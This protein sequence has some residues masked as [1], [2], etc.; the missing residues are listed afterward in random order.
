MWFD[1]VQRY[2]RAI[3]VKGRGGNRGKDLSSGNIDNNPHGN[4]IFGVNRRKKKQT[5][6]LYPGGLLW[7]W[8]EIIHDLCSW[9][10]SLDTWTKE[11]GPLHN[12]T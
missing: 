10:K 8:R 4:S 1:L 9:R 7:S 11:K 12:Y 5:E 2:D 3:F 6:I